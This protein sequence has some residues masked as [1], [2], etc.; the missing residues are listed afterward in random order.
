MSEPLKVKPHPINKRIYVLELS[1]G[2]TKLVTKNLVQGKRVYGERLYT[3]AGEEYREWIPYRSK[4][5]AAVL[6]GIKGVPIEE[7]DSVL[8]LGAASGTT[9]S[10]VSDIIGEK[11]RARRT[12]EEMTGTKIVVGKYHVAIIGSYERAMAAK[13]AVE[14]LAEG[15]QHGTVYRHIDTMMRSIKRREAVGLWRSSKEEF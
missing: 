10:H 6:N 1:D 12:L 5:A 15:R 3:I 4:L 9:P 13:R 2:T 8:Y 11:G 7:G 14:M